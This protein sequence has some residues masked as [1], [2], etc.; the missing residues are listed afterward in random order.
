MVSRSNLKP[1]ATRLANDCDPGPGVAD[2]DAGVRGPVTSGDAANLEVCELA[3]SL[4][5]VT[6]D[7]GSE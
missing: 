5:D 7:T 6:R 4:T 2:A 3:D 1:G